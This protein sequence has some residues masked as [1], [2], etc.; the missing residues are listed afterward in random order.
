MDASAVPYVAAAASWP[1][2]STGF[3][4]TASAHGLSALSRDALDTHIAERLE[5][6]DL[7][8]FLD[9]T[10]D[11]ITLAERSPVFAD[12]LAPLLGN[13]RD[14]LDALPAQ[15]LSR[16][17]RDAVEATVERIDA[18]LESVEAPGAPE[19]SDGTAEVP[20]GGL[21]AHENAGGHLIER[22]VAKSE[23]WLLDRVSRDNISAASSFR[24]LPEAE[25]FVSATIA[26][27]QARVDAWA[28]GSG[29]NRLVIDTTFDASTGI[30]VS[31]GDT[32]AVDVFSVRLV[33][34]RS[35]QL[36]IGYR[37]V[38]GYPSKP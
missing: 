17:E 13:I 14:A 34:E 2:L 15:S 31:R 26:D 8:G 5:A 23:Q 22:H 38:T 28:D 33:L 21:D 19:G 32:R 20:G 27:H 24:N 11:A 18:Y 10:R 25:H 1:V 29:G 35:D 6:G 30:S 4:A 37:I 16:V 36:D 9:E 12:E 7:S 3:N